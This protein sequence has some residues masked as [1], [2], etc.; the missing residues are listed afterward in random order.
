MPTSIS[1]RKSSRFLIPEGT[2]QILKSGVP[3]GSISPTDQTVAIDGA[4]FK[5]FLATFTKSVQENIL[6]FIPQIDD[7]TSIEQYQKAVNF[8]IFYS[9]TQNLLF[10]TSPTAITK[11]FLS[12]LKKVDNVNLEYSTLAFDLEAISNSMASTRGIR[13]SSEDIGVSSKALNGD[14]V[15]VNDEAIEAL[16]SGTATQILGNIDILNKS[17]T[18]LLTQSG[19]LVVYS[20]I[21]DLSTQEYPML[22]FSLATLKELNII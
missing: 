17:R 3:I 13:F 2:T 5:K 1:I 4:I 11:V 10:L 14:E 22:E 21:I 6:V 8:D 16:E 19:T 20:S 7:Y 18:I 12:E 9:E 15:D